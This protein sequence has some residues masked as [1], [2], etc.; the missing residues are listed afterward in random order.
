MITPNI[1]MP[2]TN[3][4]TEQRLITGLRNSDSGIS[5]SAAFDSA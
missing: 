2:S 1:P 3:T 5:G 4:Q